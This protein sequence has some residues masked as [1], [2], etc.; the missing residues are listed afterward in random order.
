MSGGMNTGWPVL[1]TGKKQQHDSRLLYFL[2]C[3]EASLDCIRSVFLSGSVAVVAR[4]FEHVGASNYKFVPVPEG[5]VALV[6]VKVR[7]GGGGELRPYLIIEAVYQLEG[8]ATGTVHI[9]CVET[10]RGTVY[11]GPMPYKPEGEKE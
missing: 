7:E 2:P 4:Y 1:V 5:A 11:C 8:G 6:K 3:S 10:S 9:V